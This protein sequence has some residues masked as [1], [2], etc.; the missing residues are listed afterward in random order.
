L[1]LPPQFVV[2]PPPM[3]VHMHQLPQP[4]LM[5]TQSPVRLQSSPM[6]GLI[7]SFPSDPALKRGL[8]PAHVIL[9]EAPN[10]PPP[11]VRMPPLVQ[12]GEILGQPHAV[13]D[14]ISGQIRLPVMPP[15]LL[16]LQCHP[17]G[18]Q[19]AAPELSHEF[20]E[21]P[22]ELQNNANLRLQ[23]RLDHPSAQLQ[24][25]Y[26]RSHILPNHT[27]EM[28]Q[29]SDRLFSMQSEPLMPPGQMLESLH[30]LPAQETSHLL[31]EPSMELSRVGKI[32]LEVSNPRSQE[33]VRVQN[34]S[35]PVVEHDDLGCLEQ[36]GPSFSGST[37]SSRLPAPAVVMA[38]SQNIG[39]RLPDNRFQTEFRYR[40]FTD[41]QEGD[42]S[43]D[44]PVSTSV[45]R[46]R[47]S[48]H[49]SEF[50]ST[51]KDMSFQ[52][53][54]SDRVRIPSA[55]DENLLEWNYQSSSGYMDIHSSLPTIRWNDENIDEMQ[56]VGELKAALRQQDDMNRRRTFRHFGDDSSPTSSYEPLRKFMK[57]ADDSASEPKDMLQ[58]SDSKSDSPYDDDAAAASSLAAVS[59]ASPSPSSTELL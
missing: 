30:G 59:E 7:P 20:P 48:S 27:R 19:L 11:V 25:E 17:V 45:N 49:L 36:H 33:F 6:M 3:S 34:M 58:A 35:L 5:T 12:A 13:S 4:G 57:C 29:R 42:S 32:P 40:N 43:L 53:L 1:P 2:N 38:A 46:M 24:P 8:T 51:S 14:A 26:P 15:S 18:G 39:S 10:R 31:G 23:E 55:L 28:L 16:D 54:T 56:T 21:I 47:P 41:E 44:P 22:P 52:Q 37:F 50:A 9:H